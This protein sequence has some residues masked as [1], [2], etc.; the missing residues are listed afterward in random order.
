MV[1]L[2]TAHMTEIDENIGQRKHAWIIIHV[3]IVPYFDQ[4]IG[5]EV[6]LLI[7]ARLHGSKSPRVPNL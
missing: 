4:S 1:P 5:S 6:P 2:H 3:C 7:S